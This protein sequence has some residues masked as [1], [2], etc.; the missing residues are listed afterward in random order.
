MHMWWF[1]AVVTIAA[2]LSTSL[3]W[4]GVCARSVMVVIL[5]ISSKQPTSRTSATPNKFHSNTTWSTQNKA[6]HRRTTLLFWDTSIVGGL[7]SL[8]HKSVVTVAAALSLL[9]CCC[10][11]YCCCCCYCCYC[12]WICDDLLLLLLLLLRCQHLLCDQA[13]RSLCSVCNGG[14]PAHFVKTANKSNKRNTQQV[15]PQNNMKHLREH[16]FL[17]RKLI[18]LRSEFENKKTKVLWTSE[19]QV[20]NKLEKS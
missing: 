12:I 11:Y 20:R 14:N 3:V 4:S 19:K 16:G 13:I 2:A 18:H 6:L 5:P 15:S 9:I 10:C 7:G 8:P 17:E 1:V